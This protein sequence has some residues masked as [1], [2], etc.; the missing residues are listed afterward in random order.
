MKLNL[1]TKKLTELFKIRSGDYHAIS[2]LESG[3]IPLVSCADTNNG[4][5]GLFDIP[6]DKT[7]QNTITVAYNGQPLTTKFHP[8]K[9]GTKDD[10][11]VLIP[12]YAMKSTTLLFIAALLNEYRWKYSYG[13]KCYREKL[14]AVTIEIP[15]FCLNGKEMLDEDTM[16]E[17]CPN[18]YSIFI[19]RWLYDLTQN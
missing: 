7:Y 6:D 5:V 3:N 2:E 18:D 4:V 16:M 19:P 9:F 12:I 10:V 14:Q 8:Y 11:A 15:V 17:F 13:R 1:S